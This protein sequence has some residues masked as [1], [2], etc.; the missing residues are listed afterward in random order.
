MN[1]ELKISPNEKD[2]SVLITAPSNDERVEKIMRKLT[3][4]EQKQ[5]TGIQNGAIYIVDLEE[6]ISFYTNDK[7][8]F[9]KTNKGEFEIN[10]R[11][12]EIEEFV[13]NDS[14]I[15]ISNG[16]MVNVKHVECFDTAQIGNIIVKLDDK[17]FEYVSKRRIPS[18]MKFLKERKDEK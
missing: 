2:I 17:S 12:Y 10:R 7:K 8:V 1:I 18:I 9:F 13:I 11:M 3:N 15:R 16:V 4:N 14:F 6:I 5:V